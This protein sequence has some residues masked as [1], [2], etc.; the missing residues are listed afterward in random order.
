MLQLSTLLLISGLGCSGKD[1]DSGAADDTTT[2]DVTDSGTGTDD[3]ATDD[4]EPGGDD[5]GEWPTDAVGELTPAITL[6]GYHPRNVLIIS[7]DTLRTDHINWAGYPARTTTPTIDSFFEGGLAFSNHYSCS[8]W[9]FPSMLCALTG[10]DQVTLGFWP[11]NSTAGGDPGA[12][13]RAIDMLAEHF[14]DRGYHTMLSSG[15]GFLGGAESETDQGFDVG[16][17]TFEVPTPTLIADAL[18]YLGDHLED[19][20]GTPWMLHLHLM[21]PHAPYNVP[22][23]YLGEIE[24]LP[25]L[26]ND[27]T[28]EE[29]VTSLWSR[30]ASL[31]EDAQNIALQHLLINYDAS[32]RYSDDQ[33]AL[34]LAE[35]E[36]MGGMENTLIVFFSDHG[37]EFYEH[38]N[39]NHGYT[40]YEEVTRAPLAFYLPGNLQP[41]NLES[42]TTHEDLV[43]TLFTIMGWEQEAGFTGAPAGTIEREHVFNMSWREDKTIQAVTDGR[44]KLVY[45]WGETVTIGGGD[46]GEEL[47]PETQKLLFDLPSD[48][49]EQDNLYDPTDPRVIKWWDALLPE[50]EALDAVEESLSPEVP[51]P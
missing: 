25:A 14:D 10:M 34:F 48:R 12:A 24:E 7:V 9:T 32:I 42:L 33:I 50:V 17:G 45:R 23:E 29:G 44:E 13:P 21:D 16:N 36:S 26:E 38:G 51:G 11:N 15:S 30:F 1:A 46:A 49:L 2:T 22:T 35:V 41:H 8:S 27:L 4:T 18:G 6:E 47:G 37:E 40:A 19:N 39:F 43:P 20:P 3:S 31:G 28:T 5:T